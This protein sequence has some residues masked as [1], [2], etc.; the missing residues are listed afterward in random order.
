SYYFFSTSSALGGALLL[1]LL[2][3]GAWA[4]Y[5]RA[6]TWW[7]L[8]LFALGS[9]GLYS[10]AT[11][12]GVRRAIPLVFVASLLLGEVLD[13][14]IRSPRLSRARVVTVAFAVALLLA[15]QTFATARALS[16]RR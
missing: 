5:R 2:A 13:W 16:T 10:I 9:I 7:P 6:L 14:A 8:W 12:T 15:S 3:G 1:P 4:S 11:P